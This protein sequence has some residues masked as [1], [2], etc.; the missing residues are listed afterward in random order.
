VATELRAF[1]ERIVLGQTLEDK[2][3]PG[4]DLTDRSPGPRIDITAPGRAERLKIVPAKDA[5]APPAE[6]MTDP[7]QR[8]RVIH[9]LA[10]HELQAVELF[11]WAVLAFPDADPSFR[12]GL[13]RLIGDEQRHTRMYIARLESCGAAFG[14]YPLSGYFWSK[15]PDIGSP[16][17]FVCAMSL[18]FE[19]ANLDHTD[20]YADAATRAGDW[21]T[22]SVIQIVQRE[23]IEHVRFGFRWLNRFKRRDQKTW[24]AY[25]SSLHWP[26]RPAK[27]KGKAFNRDGRERAGLDSEFIDRLEESRLDSDE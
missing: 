9:S 12:R 16:M 13:A 22:A 4:R 24:D 26:L 18:T 2:L 27:A 15:V 21:K 14:D 6:G 7:H 20:E 10:N 5:K 23:E 11:A 3:T 1:A 17:E 25:R 19:N 8:P